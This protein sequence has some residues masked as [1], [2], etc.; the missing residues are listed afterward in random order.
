MKNLF[1][2]LLSVFLITGLTV[3]AQIKKPIKKT[4]KA[5]NVVNNQPVKTENKIVATKSVQPVKK[6]TVFPAST[7]YKTALGLKFIYG[8]S[9]TGKFFINNNGAI[10]AIVRYNGAGG[11]GTNIALTALYEYHLPIKGVDGL[12]WYVG[13]GGFGNYFTYKDD[14]DNSVITYGVS[15]VI[16]LEYKFAKLPLAISADWVPG[17]VINDGLGFSA[18]NG[19]LGVKYTF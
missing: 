4:T 18:E 8:V 13:G 19:G 15:G 6:Q 17:Y 12:R 1:F 7:S 5:K 9:A 14:S 3:K 16:G 10:E 11:V 2:I